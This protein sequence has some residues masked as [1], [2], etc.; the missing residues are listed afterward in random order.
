MSGPVQQHDGSP[1]RASGDPDRPS[2]FG[3]LRRRKV[4]RVAITYAVASE[5][6]GDRDGDGSLESWK[7]QLMLTYS[8]DEGWLCL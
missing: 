8:A 3:E 7:R 4:V 2:F 1:Q 5:P 6:V